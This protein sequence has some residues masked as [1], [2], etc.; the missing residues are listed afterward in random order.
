MK[1]E[2]LPLVFEKSLKGGRE[3]KSVSGSEEMSQCSDS[4]RPFAFKKFLWARVQ[5]KSLSGPEKVLWRRNS[6]KV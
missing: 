5:E 3:E 6:E 1:A 2:N 4:V